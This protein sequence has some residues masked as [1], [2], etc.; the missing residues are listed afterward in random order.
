MTPCFYLGLVCPDLRSIL[1]PSGK[2]LV[3]DNPRFCGEGMMLVVGASSRVC[4][5]M[6]PHW[7]NDNASI[8]LQYR[9]NNMAPL[10]F[11][12]LVWNPLDNHSILKSW[13]SRQPLAPTSMLVL[14]GATHHRGDS[15]HVNSRIAD[16]CCRA[17][18]DSGI[19]RVFVASS[20]A[21]YGNHLVRGFLESDDPIPVN[22]YGRSKLEMEAACLRWS[23]E[24]E[25]VC[26]RIGN[27]V[28][29][30]ALL[31]KKYAGSTNEVFI[32]CFRDGTTPRRSYIG[33]KTM[34]QILVQL[35]AVER[36]L[37]SIINLAAP[38]PVQMGDLA[39]SAGLTWRK[40]FREDTVGQSITMDCTML[41]DIVSGIKAA[42]TPPEL[43]AQIMAN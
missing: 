36:S 33:P 11:P 4:Q 21:V 1:V 9:Q 17:A 16:A 2:I 37:P 13:L 15:L 41:W 24:I 3:S 28:G 14:A 10:G 25:V 22:Q 32:D 26:L 18:L 43:I 31:S 30:D 12:G 7:Q 42:S 5:L 39:D 40:R 34:A 29:A 19:R 23:K 8:A 38:T 35:G 6:L 20:S 27:V